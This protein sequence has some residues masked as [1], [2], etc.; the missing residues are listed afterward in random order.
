MKWDVTL[1]RS[2][3]RQ[4]IVYYNG[5]RISFINLFEAHRIANGNYMCMKI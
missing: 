5:L 3:N 2:F 4:V 1:T